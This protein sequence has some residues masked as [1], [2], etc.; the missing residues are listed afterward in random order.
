MRLPQPPRRTFPQG[1]A[2]AVADVIEALEADRTVHLYR[3]TAFGSST[4]LCAALTTG[5]S[6]WRLGDLASLSP[7]A[8][9]ATHRFF[10]ESERWRTWMQHTEA[11]PATF[12]ARYDAALARLRPLADDAITALGGA[13][14]PLPPPGFPS[15]WGR[16]WPDTV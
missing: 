11:M 16:A 9:D 7:A 10:E 12:E 1:V 14:D 5:W 6:Q 8:L 15:W 2:R 13:P 4:D 3:W